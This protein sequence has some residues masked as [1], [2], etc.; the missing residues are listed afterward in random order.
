MAKRVVLLF[1]LCFSIQAVANVDSLGL[2]ERLRAMLWDRTWENKSNSN[3]IS[4]VKKLFK[5]TKFEDSAGITILMVAGAIGDLNAVKYLVEKSK[6]DAEVK[7]IETGGKEKEI[8]YYIPEKATASLQ[9]LKDILGNNYDVYLNAFLNIRVNLGKYIGAETNHGYTALTYAVVTGNLDISEYVL[10]QVEQRG[11]TEE[12]IFLINHK[13]DS[14]FTSLLYAASYKAYGYGEGW[15]LVEEQK[16]IGI[17]NLLVING[18]ETTVTGH[19]KEGDLDMLGTA[20]KYGHTEIITYI[21]D[22]YSMSYISLGSK[23]GTVGEIRN[24]IEKA[25][26]LTD[27]EKILKELADWKSSLPKNEDLLLQK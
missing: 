6:D 4:E 27:N 14:G 8:F 15:F 10:E 2:D 26:A 3:V 21:K 7:L 22:W 1:L 16:R 5:D 17:F 25:E 19:F 11:G 24:S 13:D 23:L 9:S 18:A 20:S 12:K